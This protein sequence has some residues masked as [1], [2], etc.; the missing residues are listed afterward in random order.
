MQKPKTHFEQ[1]PLELVKKIAQADAPAGN[2]NGKNGSVANI[3]SGKRKAHRFSSLR[4]NGKG[5]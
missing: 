1:V 2:G 4:K 3:L 5:V